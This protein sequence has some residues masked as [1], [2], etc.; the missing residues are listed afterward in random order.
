MAKPAEDRDKQGHLW[1]RVG[2]YVRPI[3]VQVG[4]TDGFQTEVSGNELKAGMPIVTGELRAT[5]TADATN[6]F[7]P[8][9][10]RGRPEQKDRQ[11]SQ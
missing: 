4:M 8:K 11:T 6:P 10:Y 7:V 9:I 5:D 3:D 1:V 2:D